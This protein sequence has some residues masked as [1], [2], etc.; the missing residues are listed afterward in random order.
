[1]LDEVSSLLNDNAKLMK[2]ARKKLGEIDPKKAKAFQEFKKDLME[3][4]QE[5]ISDDLKRYKITIIEDDDFCLFVKE[6]TH[7]NSYEKLKLTVYESGLDFEDACEVIDVLENCDDEELEDVVESVLDIVGKVMTKADKDRLRNFKS[8]YKIYGPDKNGEYRMTLNGHRVKVTEPTNGAII[9]ANPIDA[10]LKIDFQKLSK[11]PSDKEIDAV[12]QHE[13]GHRRLHTVDPECKA[14]DKR[15][16]DGQLRADVAYDILRKGGSDNR[17]KDEQNAN[18][19]LKLALTPLSKE[20][21]DK[22]DPELVEARKQFRTAMKKSHV[23]K[24]SYV[25][26]NELEADQYAANRVG[27]DALTQALD[28]MDKLDD[29]YEAIDIGKKIK[30]LI[31]ED[32]Y[33]SIKTKKEKEEYL[34]KHHKRL[35]QKLHPLYKKQHKIH[36]NETEIRKSA[37]KDTDVDKTIRRSLTYNKKR[38]SE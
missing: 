15:R 13:D 35:I 11:I 6:N 37:L 1:M 4:I 23:K 29:A 17:T 21:E 12:V 2:M 5:Q 32:E 33:Q 20:D 28:H 18:K 24:D 31:N 19:I 3:H 7:M 22:Q 25:D 16:T 30:E 10:S 34:E 27:V 9:A 36:L 26:A 8:R 38:R 14:M